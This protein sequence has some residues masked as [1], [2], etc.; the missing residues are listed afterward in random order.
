MNRLAVIKIKKT[1]TNI[2]NLT[3]KELLYLIKSR[4]GGKTTAR[5]IDAILEGPYN[6]NQL[7]K[8]LQ[9]DYKTICYHIQ[10]ISKYDYITQEKFEQNYYYR[11]SK[12]LLKNINEYNLIKE[13]I[14]NEGKNEK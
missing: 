13:S 10:L 12:K 8:K 6:R 11:P 3:N 2:W 9:L 5:I 7:S 4:D 14:K 1:E